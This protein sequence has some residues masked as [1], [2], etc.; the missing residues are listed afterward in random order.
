VNV[1]SGRRGVSYVPTD[2]V[3][4]TEILCLL[5]LLNAQ[6]F[7][8]NWNLVSCVS[9]ISSLKSRLQTWEK[10]IHNKEVSEETKAIKIQRDKV[11]RVRVRRYSNAFFYPSFT[12]LENEFSNQ[13]HITWTVPVDD[14][15]QGFCIGEIFAIFLYYNT[16]TNVGVRHQD[17]MQ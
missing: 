13:K 14:K 1:I 17:V 10:S 11:S 9:Y 12:D 7:L 16:T 15:I 8:E 2:F 4:R 6:Y 5:D 3:F